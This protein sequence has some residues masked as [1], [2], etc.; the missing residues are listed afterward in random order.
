MML[1][2]LLRI[3]STLSLL[4]TCKI[5]IAVKSSYLATPHSTCRP[6]I[7]FSLLSL[8]IPLVCQKTIYESCIVLLELNH[9]NL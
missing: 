3:C 5:Y 7:T 9:D 8:G 2:V 6:N 1:W 4:R